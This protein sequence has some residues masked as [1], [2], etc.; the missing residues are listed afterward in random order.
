MTRIALVQMRVVEGEPEINVARAQR[1]L[2]GADR[3]DVYL[4]PELW[5]SGYAHD[6]WPQIADHSTPNTLEWMRVEARA[7]NATIGGSLI[8][9]TRNGGLANRFWSISPDGS[10]IW[11]D[12]GHLFAP[13]GEDV[14]L[15]AGTCRVSARIAGWTA[16]LSVCFDLRFPEQYRL[17]AVD[18]AELFLVVSAWPEP[19]CGVLGA[20]A[21]ARAI[22]NQAVLAICNRVGPGTPDLTYCGGSV[23]VAPDGMVLADAGSAEGVVSA[24]ID[25]RMVWEARAT[26]PVLSLRAAGLDW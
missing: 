17:D 11:Y 21:R 25:P 8:S 20:L 18:G 24:D 13:L 3:S 26:L 5:S 9:R 7:R 2:A 19:R 22:E 1:L 16:A 4:L 15:A 14:H 10:V 23:I 12:K 6:E